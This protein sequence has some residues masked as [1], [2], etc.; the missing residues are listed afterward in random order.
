M[1]E[2]LEKALKPLYEERAK[3]YLNGSRKWSFE[4][5]DDVVQIKDDRLLIE[6]P[7]R[8]HHEIL[9][10]DIR[11]IEWITGR[12]DRIMIR[13]KR[14]EFSLNYLAG[15]MHIL[16][17]ILKNHQKLQGR[18]NPFLHCEQRIEQENLQPISSNVIGLILGGMLFLSMTLSALSFSYNY[19]SHFNQ[20]G[21]YLYFAWIA[22]TSFVGAILQARIF[23]SDLKKIQSTQKRLKE[24]DKEL[25]TLLPD[26]IIST[27]SYVEF[28]VTEESNRN[29]LEF[30]NVTICIALGAGMLTMASPVLLFL[31]Q[32]ED[33]SLFKFVFGGLAIGVAIMTVPTALIEW[34]RRAKMRELVLKRSPYLLD[35][36]S[37]DI[38][39]VNQTPR[40]RWANISLDNI[41]DFG[42][43]KVDQNRKEI[44]YEGEKER[45]II[46]ASALISWDLQNSSLNDT[47]I[48]FIALRAKHPEEDF[49]ERSFKPFN[50]IGLEKNPKK[51]LIEIH[52]SIDE[53]L[54]K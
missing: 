40:E 37:P 2:L 52:E 27:S 19:F 28:S 31:S 23:W 4:K 46:P 44:V 13:H 45:F 47:D 32:G 9:F 36:T 11:Y 3:D 48:V 29:L 30:G 10:S 15:D 5:I 35:P 6:Y 22:F 1:L 49:W 12:R 25:Y 43:L 42:F 20:S 50:I 38:F 54:R 39:Y 8:K 7:R 18:V 17:Y 51:Q 21:D 16:L 26:P 24:L 41:R 34:M 33:A 14:G 53:M